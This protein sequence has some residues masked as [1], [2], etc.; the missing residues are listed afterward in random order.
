MRESD[1]QMAALD[2]G[3]SIGRKSSYYSNH[4][5]GYRGLG[6]GGGFEIRK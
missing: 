1:N 5:V 3:E 2:R 4:R 6:V